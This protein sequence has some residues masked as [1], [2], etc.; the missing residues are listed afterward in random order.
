[1]VP[2]CLYKVSWKYKFSTQFKSYLQKEQDM[3][4]WYTLPC[5][6]KWRWA[7]PE[8]FKISVLTAHGSRAVSLSQK[9]KNFHFLLF[10]CVSDTFEWFPANVCIPTVIVPFP[11]SLEKL[12][13]FHFINY[14]VCLKNHAKIYGYGITVD[15]G[16]LFLGS[17]HSHK[18]NYILIGERTL[19]TSTNSFP[20]QPP[21]SEFLY[22]L[23]Q[24][25]AQ[26]WHITFI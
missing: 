23:Y 5:H 17:S 12:Q 9:I 11:Q 21:D 26:T 1:M 24:N 3:W 22:S 8:A 19:Y 4:P 14:T 2:R 6:S 25:E 18:T 15:K 16:Y 13:R 20:R 7:L 10:S